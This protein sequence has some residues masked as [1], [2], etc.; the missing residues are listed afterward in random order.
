MRSVQKLTLPP[1]KSAEPQASKRT[2]NISGLVQ[3]EGVSSGLSGCSTT[4]PAA[5][6]LPRARA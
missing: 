5:Q 2:Q 1:S 4:A 3:A 6:P